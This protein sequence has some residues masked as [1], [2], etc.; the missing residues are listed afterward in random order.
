MDKQ[1]NPGKNIIITGERHVG[2]STA[3]GKA[4][5]ALGRPFHGFQTRF[6]GAPDQQRA[7]ILSPYGGGRGEIAAKWQDGQR[8]VFLSVFD[9]LGVKLLSGNG[10]VT[11]MDELGRFEADA[12]DFRRAVTAVFDSDADVLAVI[13]LDA[14]AWMQELKYRSDVTVITVTPEN[15]DG[16]PAKILELIR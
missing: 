16:I 14:A 4:L 6:D 15:R 10:G 7:L 3:A 11:V 13:R 1:Q 2:K 8:Q 12:N 5:A 9:T